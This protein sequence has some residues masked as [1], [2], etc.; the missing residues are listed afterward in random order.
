VAPGG[1]EALALE[2]RAQRLEKRRRLVVVD[3]DRFRVEQDHV[4]AAELPVS[5]REQRPGEVAG[6]DAVGGGGVRGERQGT[7]AALPM[8][9]GGEC[10]LVR[11]RQARRF[12]VVARDRRERAEEPF[13]VRQ[14]QVA[15]HVLAGLRQVGSER[16]EQVH[17]PIIRAALHRL[18]RVRSSSILAA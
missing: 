18:R 5:R 11:R 3:L 9:G 16:D 10:A 17:G 13:Q 12:A 7:V 6:V 8:P 15:Q 14:G 1:A 4:V 2:L